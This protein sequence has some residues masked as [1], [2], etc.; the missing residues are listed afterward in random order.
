ML[1][2]DSLVHATPIFE[3]NQLSSGPTAT[4]SPSASPC[5][6]GHNVRPFFNSRTNSGVLQRQAS[7]QASHSD[8]DAKAFLIEY[9]WP[10]GLQDTFIRNLYKIPIRF[11]ICDDSG[12]VI[13]YYCY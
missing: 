4:P 3:G 13:N 8:S 11:F 10:Q 5:P 6:S 12:S 2:R 1:K 7:M 9:H